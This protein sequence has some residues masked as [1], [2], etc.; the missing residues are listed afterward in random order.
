M[1]PC[2]NILLPTSIVAEAIRN[3]LNLYNPKVLHCSQQCKSGPSS[4]VHLIQS[5]PFPNKLPKTHL[6]IIPP[7]LCL[8]L[9]GGLIPTIY[10]QNN[11]PLSDAY[12]VSHSKIHSS[13]CAWQSIQCL[14]AVMRSCQTPYMY[15]Y[16]LYVMY[17]A[18]PVMSHG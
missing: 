10:D 17:G 9:P 1:T 16:N 13:C 4:Q 5:T 11:S 18:A 14:Q 8:G 3:S 12:D 6:N 2:Y 7:H 15:L